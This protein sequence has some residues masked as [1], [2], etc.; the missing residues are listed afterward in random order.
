METIKKIHGL[1]ESYQRLKDSVD[2][3]PLA[4][5]Y[6]Y[7]FIWNNHS[8]SLVQISNGWQNNLSWEIWVGGDEDPVQMGSRNACLD[9]MY[10]TW[11]GIE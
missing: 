10:R 1:W 9:Y 2:I 6:M 8:A 3:P 4:G 7:Q 5:K 11:L